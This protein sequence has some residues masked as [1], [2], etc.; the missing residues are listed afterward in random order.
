MAAKKKW[1]MA[2]ET[3][4]GLNGTEESYGLCG[5]RSS[6]MYVNKFLH[7]GFSAS[8]I[9]IFSTL[10]GGVRLGL[11]RKILVVLL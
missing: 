11:V 7:G 2:M 6:H 1:K 9:N 3:K 4:A 8:D 10:A 5:Y